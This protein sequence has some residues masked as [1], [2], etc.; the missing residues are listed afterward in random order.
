MPPLRESLAWLGKVADPNAV[1][2]A[3]YG[4]FAN[5]AIYFTNL[6]IVFDYTRYYPTLSELIRTVLPEALSISPS[7]YAVGFYEPSLLD[8]NFKLVYITNSTNPMQIAVFKYYDVLSNISRALTIS[9]GNSTIGWTIYNAKPGAT[10]SIA[11]D[12]MDRVDGNASIRAD[13]VGTASYWTALSYTGHID[14]TGVTYLTLWTK[15]SAVILSNDYVV[16]R[17]IDSSGNYLEWHVGEEV[18]SS[19]GQLILEVSAALS[20]SG[21]KPIFSSI[22]SIEILYIQ[23]GDKPFSFWVDDVRAAWTY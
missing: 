5:W 15:T 21:G 20:P 11:S 14:L 3:R 8:M 12:A 9:S 19:W 10:V 22:S 1:V 17:I 18:S 16:V 23:S 2:I 13:N 7:V 4:D 6:Q